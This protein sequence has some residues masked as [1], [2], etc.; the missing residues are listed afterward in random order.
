M[1]KANRLGVF[2]LVVGAT[3]LMVTVFRGMSPIR[4]DSGLNVP[5]SS[6]TIPYEEFWLPRSIR[7]EV[8]AD[9]A[10]DL[11]IL[12]ENGI[13]LWQ[14]EKRL[15]PLYA[16]NQT[17][18][19]IYTV[20]IDRRGIYSFLFYNLSNSTVEVDMN[21][22]VYGFE[23]DLLWASIIIAVLGAITVIAQRFI[24]AFYKKVEEGTSVKK[25]L[26][27]PIVVLHKRH[28]WAGPDLNRRPSARQ[29]DVLTRLDDRPLI[30]AAILDEL[31]SWQL[32]ESS[33]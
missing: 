23:Q 14:Q 17:R 1:K 21:I 10:V 3:L 12:D 30:I 7:I 15:S 26:L 19:A 32:L 20:N 31:F 28:W 9:S 5:P 16:F 22:T 18:S 25:W 33:I 2:L 29:A 13:Y 27:K 4:S 6:W 24:L 8:F 11:F